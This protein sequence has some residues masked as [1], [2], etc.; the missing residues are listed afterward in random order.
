MTVGI[1][2]FFKSYN[3]G[4]WLQAVATQE[5]FSKN[6]FNAEIINYTNELEDSNGFWKSIYDIGTGILLPM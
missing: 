2:T 3:Y 5:F 1:I 4:V 6:G